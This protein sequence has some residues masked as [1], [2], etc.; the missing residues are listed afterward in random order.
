MRRYL[1]EHARRAKRR[2]STA[3]LQKLR[4]NG[5]PWPRSPIRWNG[6]HGVTLVL[7]M[8]TLSLMF[9]FGSQVIQSAQ[10]EARRASL[11]AEVAQFATQ[12]QQ[13]LGVVEYAESDANVERVARE[14][15]GY[16]RDGDIVILP[17][18]PLPTPTPTAEK[19]SVQPAIIPA[20]NWQRWWRALFPANVVQ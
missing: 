12:N 7:A 9:N 8:L 3:W 15:L 2:S 6:V 11:A 16:A 10:L 17:Q 19:P 20:P 13:L 4:I 5:L 18:V 1:A 14:Q